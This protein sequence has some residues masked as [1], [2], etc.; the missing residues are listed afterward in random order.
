VTRK[1]NLID[2]FPSLS[3]IDVDGSFMSAA[4]LMPSVFSPSKLAGAYSNQLNH[5]GF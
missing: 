2:R 5:N 4:A 1:T 3:L